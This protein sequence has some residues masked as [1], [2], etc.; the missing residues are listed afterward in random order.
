[1]RCVAIQLSKITRADPGHRG[2]AS[3]T[4]RPGARSDAVADQVEH[5]PDLGDRR[6]WIDR[7]GEVYRARCLIM[8]DGGTPDSEGDTRW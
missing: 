6:V 2:A 5:G 3:P 7:M 1:M 4:S 8:H